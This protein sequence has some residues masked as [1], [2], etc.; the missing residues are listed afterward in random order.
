MVIK[1]LSGTKGKIRDYVHTQR[2]VIRERWYRTQRIVAIYSL[3]STSLRA[4]HGGGGKKRRLEIEARRRWKESLPNKVDVIG[5][6][7]TLKIHRA[8]QRHRVRIN[9]E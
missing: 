6:L 4:R 1:V 2:S 8:R 9:T 5:R 7:V 3:G